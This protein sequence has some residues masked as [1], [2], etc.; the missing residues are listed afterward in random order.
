MISQ[1]STADETASQISQMRDCINLAI[2]RTKSYEILKD[3]D[4]DRSPMKMRPKSLYCTS[5][6]IRGQI[7]ENDISPEEDPTVIAVKKAMERSD[8]MKGLDK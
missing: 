6:P 7:P 1:N 3:I 5:T 2:S 8:L 4:T